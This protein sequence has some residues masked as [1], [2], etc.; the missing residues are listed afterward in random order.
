M[1][2]ADFFLLFFFTRQFD[3]SMVIHE[4]IL[5]YRWANGQNGRVCK[6]WC[7]VFH[8]SW[9]CSGDELIKLGISLKT[10]V[11]TPNLLLIFQTYFA[12]FL[13]RVMLTHRKHVEKY[14]GSRR[15]NFEDG[16]S[17]STFPFY[18]VLF[19]F[20][21]ESEVFCRH[22]TASLRLIPSHFLYFLMPM[23]RGRG[24]GSCDGRFEG[25]YTTR[26]L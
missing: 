23:L 22:R 16:K 17:W 20:Q 3:P 12:H 8:P 4:W 11:D 15:I 19:L 5:H 25:L 6:V 10:S 7:K 21:D 1:I 9:N 2:Y 24:I 13:L 14:H 18:D 26:Y